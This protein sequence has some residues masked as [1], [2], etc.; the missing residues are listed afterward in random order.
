MDSPHTYKYTASNTLVVNLYT[1]VCAPYC[2]VYMYMRAKSQYLPKP[3][4]RNKQTELNCK[5]NMYKMETTLRALYYTSL[6]KCW[7][8][9]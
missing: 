9:S 5:I 8:A 7:I 2:A 4:H 6:V 3:H 1:R